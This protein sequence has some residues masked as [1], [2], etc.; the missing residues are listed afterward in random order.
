MNYSRL[1]NRYKSK[2]WFWLI[3]VFLLLQL[4]SFIDVNPFRKRRSNDFTDGFSAE[5][6]DDAL[7]RY[8]Q[9]KSEYKL[10]GIVLHWQRRAG[11]QN[12]VKTMIDFSDL[13]SEILVWNNN[14][15]VNLT[16]DDLLIEERENVRIINSKEN[17]KDVAKYRACEHAKTKAC[18]YVDDD[19]DIRMYARSLYASYL[20]EPTILHATT[21]QFTYFTNIMWTF[22]DEKIQLHTGF[23]WIGCG[24]IFSRENAIRH[25]KYL[26]IFLREEE[27]QSKLNNFV[28][29]RR[30]LF[31]FVSFRFVTTKKPLKYDVIDATRKGRVTKGEKAASGG[32]RN[33]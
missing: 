17:I 11:V 21:D 13:F 2:L 25:L 33:Q 8:E 14:P 29:H 5:D 1:F 22:F 23:S 6:V 9:I 28:H 18:F 32:F 10:T 26:D 15:T 19:W 3:I 20:L 31:S 12:L 16:F 30:F 24:S 4:V 7:N 27:Y